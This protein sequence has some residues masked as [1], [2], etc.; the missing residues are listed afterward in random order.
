MRGEAARARELELGDG[1]ERGGLGGSIYRQ[2]WRKIGS[3]P[4]GF[5][6]GLVKVRRF[7]IKF[8]RPI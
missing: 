2:S 4:R 7:G 5:G 8:I 1:N 6:S 3:D